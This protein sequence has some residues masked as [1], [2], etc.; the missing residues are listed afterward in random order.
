MN[1]VP[2][3]RVM[4]VLNSLEIGGAEMVVVRLLEARREPDSVVVTLRRRGSLAARIEAHGIPVV[5]L[6]VPDRRG[7]PALAAAVRGAIRRYRPAI[8][9]SHNVSPLVAT[10]AA[11]VGMRKVRHVHTEHGR[12]DP[13][14]RAARI[15]YRIASRRAS[16]LVAV[17]EDTARHASELSG[18]PVSQFTV[19]PNGV[20]LQ[21]ERAAPGPANHL[22]TVARLE[23][24]KDIAT[25]LRAVARLRQA[26]CDVR[27]DVHG[28]GAERASLQ[29]LAAELSIADAVVFHGMTADIAS[30]LASAGVYVSSSLSE[31]ISLTI[32]EAMSVGL[33][34]VATA[35]GG[36]PEIVRD[37]INGYLVPPA[38]PAAMFA[39]LERLIDHPGDAARMGS[40]SRA[41]IERTY[42]LD[43]M[44]RQ[45]EHLYRCP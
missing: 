18:V 26:S 27:L 34:V 35:V 2:R 15:G 19:I 16:C 5:S 10:A 41:S 24:V 33:P 8:V 38:D 30:A 6:G 37:G 32:L 17:S 25:I 36:T 23:A 4:H 1:A 42:S 44:V 13:Q 9:H 3:T 20:A 40:A 29:A 12:A 31:G 21:P 28:D 45:Y 39:A 22:I 11:T 43:I 7:V 14:S